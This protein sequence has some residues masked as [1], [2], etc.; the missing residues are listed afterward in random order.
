MITLFILIKIKYVT[1]YITIRGGHRIGVTGNIVIKDGQVTNISHI[2]SLNFRIARQVLNCSDSALNY[3]IDLMNN[4]VY[5]TII[6]SPPGR[7]KTTLLRDIIRKISSG[8][9][10]YHFKGINVGVVD[11]R[12]EIAA[13]YKGEPQNDVGPRTDILDNVPKAI[14]MRMLIRSM[15]PKV[16]VADEIGSKEDVDAINYAICCRS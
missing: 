12:G 1:G 3:M 14:G 15:N 11:E 16:I 8:I 5:N 10:E 9:S 7:G 6:I 2:Y 4:S 13:M